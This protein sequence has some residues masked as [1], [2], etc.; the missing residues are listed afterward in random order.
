M[1]PPEVLA[2]TVRVKDWDEV[3]LG[4]E[5][6][7]TSMVILNEPVCEVVPESDPAGCTVIPVG[8]VPDESVQA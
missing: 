2:A 1:G 5:E 8:S 7:L 4:E 6:S 3:S